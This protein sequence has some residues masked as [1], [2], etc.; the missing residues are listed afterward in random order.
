MARKLDD[1]I[2]T[3]PNNRKKRVENRAME[4]ATVIDLRLAV[5]QTQEQMAEALSANGGDALL[6]GEFGNSEDEGLSW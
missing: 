2:A 3:L 5:Q 1:V 6:M 4:L